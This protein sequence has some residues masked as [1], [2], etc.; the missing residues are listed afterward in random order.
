MSQEQRADERRRSYFRGRVFYGPTL[1][2][3]ADCAVQNVTRNGAKLKIPANQPLPDAFVLLLISEGVAMDCNL[4]WRRA[5]MAGVN[6]RARHELSEAT[7]PRLRGV[8]A[9]W[10]SL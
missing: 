10:R 9:V 8:V 6:F 3:W 7:D 1:A 2:L 4:R 5:D